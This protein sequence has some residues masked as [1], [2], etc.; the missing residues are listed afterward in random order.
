LIKREEGFKATPYTD[1]DGKLRI[2]HGSDT[3]T[4]P[5]G[6]FQPVTSA[7]HVDAA[8]AQRDLDRRLQTEFLPQAAKQIGGDAWSGISQNSKDAIASVTYNYGHVPDS[9]VAAARSGS[10]QQVADA[11]AGLSSNPE[12]RQRESD[13]ILGGGLAGAGQQ[14]AQNAGR[15]LAGAGQAISDYAGNAG[16]AITQAGQQAGGWYEKNKSWLGPLLQGIGT[17][18]SS[19]SRYLGAAALQ[20]LG[21]GAGAYQKQQES[22]TNVGNVQAATAHQNIENL[23]ALTVDRNGILMSPVVD[24]NGNPN[25]GVYWDV[26]R[27]TLPAGWRAMNPGEAAAWAAK[28]SPVANTPPAAVANTPP[29]AAANTPPAAVANTPPAA[30]VN[31]PPAAA[32]NTPPAAAANM[33]PAAAANTPPVA[34]PSG[35]PTAM[36]ISTNT[37]PKGAA[38][39][40]PGSADLST[41]AAGKAHYDAAIAGAVPAANNMTQMRTLARTVAETNTHPGASG[42]GVGGPNISIVAGA[43]QHLGEAFH[44]D[45][46]GLNNMQTEAQVMDKFRTSIGAARAQGVGSDTYA[47]MHDFANALP[48]MNLTPKANAEIMANL[49]TVSQQSRDA[50]AHAQEYARAQPTPQLRTYGNIISDYQNKYKSVDYDRMTQQLAGL[51]ENPKTAA[52]VRDMMTKY[53]DPRTQAALLE[54]AHVNPAIARVFQ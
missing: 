23:K 21:A 52:M 14:L 24:K 4:N 30:A 48:G 43:L 33:P 25:W 22:Q 1:S 44:I 54:A 51:L 26:V 3:I 46:S 36:P 27:G 28:G 12:R 13:Y 18:A 49:L 41:L 9:V 34:A 42:A 31:T 50:S 16:Q 10:D 47:A 7:S 35:Q 20:G 8:G 11:I 2:G 37:G 17:M 19:N 5:D 38:D 6:T 29:A 45:M 15:G 40:G 39:E 53:T 32:A